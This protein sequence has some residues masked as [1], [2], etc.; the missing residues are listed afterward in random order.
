MLRRRGTTA[1]LIAA[2][3]V[4]GACGSS[5]DDDTGA[6]SGPVR[7]ASID[8]AIPDLA[9]NDLQAD[10]EIPLR[11]ILGGD[12]PVLLWFWAPH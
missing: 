1:L 12:Q 10:T 4:G 9:V 5:T 11:S 2:A 7:A 3:L 6:A 8:V